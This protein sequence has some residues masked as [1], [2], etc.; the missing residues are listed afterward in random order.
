VALGVAV[1]PISKMMPVFHL[2]A[3]TQDS[4]HA[5]VHALCQRLAPSCLPNFTSDGL[6]HYVYALTAHFGQWVTVV[7]RRKHQWQVATGLVYGQ[8]K[9]AYRR[10]TL[11]GVRQV[12]RSGTREELRT[13]LMGLGMRGRLTTAV[14][15]RVHLTMRQRV[16][17][18]VRRTWSTAQDGPQLRAHIQW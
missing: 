7:G 1:D 13:A 3:R 2:G 9:K 6:N 4:A 17:A 14:V 16:A 15:E 5:L 10:R 11:V 18:L 12:M 8:V